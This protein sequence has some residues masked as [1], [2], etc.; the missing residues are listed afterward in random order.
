M[1]KLSDK[2]KVRPSVDVVSVARLA[3]P[4]GASVVALCP[5]ARWTRAASSGR[6]SVFFAQRGIMIRHWS[7]VARV[8]IRGFGAKTTF[9]LMFNH[10]RLMFKPDQDS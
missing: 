7:H 10:S 4:F 9:R 8:P 6:V 1:P 2:V 5:K 3:R